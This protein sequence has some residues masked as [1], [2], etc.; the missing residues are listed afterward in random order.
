VFLEAIAGLFGYFFVMTGGFENST[1][2]K[3]FTTYLQATSACFLAIVIT[4]IANVFVCRN[5]NKSIFTL[6]FTTNKMVIGAIIVELLL[7]FL[8]IYT[9]IGNSFF[10]THPLP[11]YIWIYLIPFALILFVADETRKFFI[12]KILK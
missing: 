3:N 1:L 4:Q 11:F 9:P 5:S 6:G 10:Q 8:I 7:S 12:N 2:S